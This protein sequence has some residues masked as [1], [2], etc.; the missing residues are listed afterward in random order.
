MASTRSI[1][2]MA[3]LASLPLA[4]AFFT[5]VAQADNGAAAVGTASNAA[6]GN[7]F[8][9]GVDGSNLG[10]SSTAEQVASSSGA[11]NQ[12][13]SAQSNSSGFTA[14]GQSDSHESL[15]WNPLP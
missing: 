3:A 10:N 14:I 15:V 2:V 8:G 9:G 6:L 1:R 4:A 7:I 13:N 11:S 12:S 5:G